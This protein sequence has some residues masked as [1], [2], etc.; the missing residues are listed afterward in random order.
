MANSTNLEELVQVTGEANVVRDALIQINK[1]Q[2]EY[3]QRQGWCEQHAVLPLS[4]LS[5][6]SAISLSSSYGYGTRQF[7]L[8]GERLRVDQLPD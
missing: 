6:P 7:D 8:Q 2:G 1:A 3:F 4:S 5:A